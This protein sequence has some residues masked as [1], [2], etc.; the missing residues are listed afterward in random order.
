[1]I[2]R[3]LQVALIILVLTLLGMGYYALRLKQHSEAMQQV[4]DTR[5]APPLTAGPQ[6]SVTVYYANDEDASIQHAPVQVGSSQHPEVR[7]RDVL[8]QLIAMYTAKGSPHFM[9]PGADVRSVFVVNDTLAI[10][11]LNSAF[12]DAHRSG[13]MEEQ[14]TIVSLVQTVSSVLPKVTRV[15]FLVEGKPRETL[16]GHADLRGTYDVASV[17]QLARELQ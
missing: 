8:R 15:Q 9:A 5:P 6:E 17:A 12:A 7:A 11:D 10:V 16:A 3:R 14:L 4:S 1:M 2:S 13:I